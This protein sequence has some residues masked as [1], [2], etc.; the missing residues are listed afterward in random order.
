MLISICLCFRARTKAMS[1]STVSAIG[2]IY[3][4]VSRETSKAAGLLIPFSLTRARPIHGTLK[5][6]T[7]HAKT[8]H[9]SRSSR[10]RPLLPRACPSKHPTKLRVGRRS[11]D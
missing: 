10:A 8:R 11:I 2:D 6:A 4:R 7:G 3:G 5:R 9:R 1:E